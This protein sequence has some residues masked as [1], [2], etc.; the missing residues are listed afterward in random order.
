MKEFL[1]NTKKRLK[2]AYRDYLTVDG[3]YKC[4]LPDK[5]YLKKLYKK[6]LGK[7]MSFM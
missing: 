2:K 1:Y 6:K 5:V 7:D 4:I 3:T